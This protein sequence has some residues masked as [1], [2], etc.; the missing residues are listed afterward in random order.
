M[1]KIITIMFLVASLFAADHKMT[2]TDIDGK[3]YNI[4]GTKLGV[5]IQELKGKALFIEFFGHNCPPCLASIPHYNK[6]SKK[7]KDKLAI[8]AIEAQSYNKTQLKAFAKEKGIEYTLFT[9]QDAGEF[10]QYLAGRSGWNGAIPFLIAVDPDGKVKF[11]KAGM[12]PESS[13]ESV[14]EKLI[15]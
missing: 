14:I 15:N 5:D 8:L 6:L 12:I 3:V 9:G 11:V 4:T 2:A 1:K 10:Y 7:Y 13:L